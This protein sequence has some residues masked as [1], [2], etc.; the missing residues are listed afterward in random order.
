MRYKEKYKAINCTFRWSQGY[1]KNW[2]MVA[3]GSLGL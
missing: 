1:S 3:A 2:F